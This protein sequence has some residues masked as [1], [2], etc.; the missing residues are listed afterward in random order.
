M[1]PR[2]LLAPFADASYKSPN[3]EKMVDFLLTSNQSTVITN[4]YSLLIYGD[5]MIIF[6]I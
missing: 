1:H 2:Y 6:K 5:Q 4:F 3:M